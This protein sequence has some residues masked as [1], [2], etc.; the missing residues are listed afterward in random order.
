MDTIY[1]KGRLNALVAQA[2]RVDEVAETLRFTADRL[3]LLEKRIVFLEKCICLLEEVVNTT[4]SK[5][6]VDD[7]SVP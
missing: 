2:A 7:G 5:E 4:S 1:A 6:Q 3:R